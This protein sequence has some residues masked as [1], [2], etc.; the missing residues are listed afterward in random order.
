[1]RLGGRSRVPAGEDDWVARMSTVACVLHHTF[2]YFHW[3]GFYCPHPR[4]RDLLVIGPYQGHL[5]CLRIPYSRGVCGAAARTRQTQLV[6]DV[7]AFEGYIA[8]ASRCVRCWSLS[9]AA[10]TAADLKAVRGGYNSKTAATY[11]LLPVHHQCI[12]EQRKCSTTNLPPRPSTWPPPCLPACSTKSE[13]VVPVVAPPGSAGTG[14]GGA[15]PGVPAAT[16]PPLLAVLDVDSDHAAAFDHNDQ[17]RLE[18]VCR[19]LADMPGGGERGAR[20]GGG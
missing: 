9:P 2:E 4:E 3:T 16:G 1:M 10:R 11:L 13:V 12:P 14:Q 19:L 8:C 6:P 5:G 20:S 17:Q 7:T 18:E 15:G